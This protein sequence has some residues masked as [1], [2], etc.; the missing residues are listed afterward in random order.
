MIAKRRKNYHVRRAEQIAARVI[1]H[2]APAW[3]GRNHAEAE[4]T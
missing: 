4:K 2:C 3:R 1:E